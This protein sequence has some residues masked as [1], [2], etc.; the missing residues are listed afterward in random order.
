MTIWQPPTCE[1]PVAGQTSRD[2]H[3][4]SHR[5]HHHLWRRRS[6]VWNRAANHGRACTAGNA[7]APVPTL[8]AATRAEWPRRALCRQRGRSAP[9]VAPAVS[10]RLCEYMYQA[11][12]YQVPLLA[13]VASDTH[14]C[15]F[16]PPCLD[17]AR[18]PHYHYWFLSHYLSQSSPTHVYTLSYSFIPAPAPRVVLSCHLCPDSFFLIRIHTLPP[19]ARSRKWHLCWSEEN[20]P[21]KHTIHTRAGRRLQVPLLAKVAPGTHRC[22]YLAKSGTSHSQV[23]LL[24][25]LPKVAPHTH[26]CHSRGRSAPLPPVPDCVQEPLIHLIHT[27]RRSTGHKLNEYD[28][29][30]PK[31]VAVRLI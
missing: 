18:V 12:G 7:N 6:R 29:H 4:R 24:P 23:P 19:G 1:L 10:V 14:R 25:I 11:P 22:H 15:H 16:G 3:R 2:P 8:G 26:R 20:A 5:D 21:T 17:G 30:S 28:A 9:R 31:M 27:T 13:K